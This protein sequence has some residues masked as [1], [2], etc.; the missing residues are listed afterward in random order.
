MAKKRT[1]ESSQSSPEKKVKRTVR[2]VCVTGTPGVGKT[3]ICSMVKERLGEQNFHFIN[4]GELIS[5]QRLYSEWD[6][7]MNCSIFDA[8]LVTAELMRIVKNLSKGNKRGLLLDFHSVGF[9]PRTLVDHVVVIRTDT[10]T[11]WSRLEARG[12][13]ESKIKENVEAEIFMESL[14]EAM[15]KFGESVVTEMTNN[16][17][18]DR[19]KIVRAASD[20]L[21]GRE[22]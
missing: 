2:V 4:I 22:I 12:Y 7:E 5:Q 13:K 14:N 9:I 21:E 1:S 19:D 10:E 17:S 3:T 8:R 11:L 6:D 16:S 20:L 15:D 18:S